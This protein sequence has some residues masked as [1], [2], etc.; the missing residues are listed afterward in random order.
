MDYNKEREYNKFADML[1][2]GFFSMNELRKIIS[3]EFVAEASSVQSD[4]NYPEYQ[5]Y[6][7]QLQDG[8]VYYIYVL[9]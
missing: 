4:P 6:K 7:I 8:D 3:S 5:K 9:P 1:I 2:K